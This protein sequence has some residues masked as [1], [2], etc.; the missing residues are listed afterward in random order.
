MAEHKGRRAA[1]IKTGAECLVVQYDNFNFFSQ[2]GLQ[3]ECRTWLEEYKEQQ[4]VNRM[5]RCVIHGLSFIQCLMSI[6]Y[7]SSVLNELKRRGWAQEI[8]TIGSERGEHTIKYNSKLQAECQKE[9]SAT[10]EQLPYV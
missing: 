2:F 6:V 4:A 5:N 3:S 10:G 9:L 8:A 7:L 1:T